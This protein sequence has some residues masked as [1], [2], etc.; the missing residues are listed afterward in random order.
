MVYEMYIKKDVL[1][2]PY[3]VSMLLRG[4]P[5]PAKIPSGAPTQSMGGKVPA[6]PNKFII[7]QDC[8][9]LGRLFSIAIA[10]VERFFSIDGST[11]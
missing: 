8:P 1:W 3:L 11:S 2:E 9:W 6:Q 4:N 7:T 5:Y 10:L